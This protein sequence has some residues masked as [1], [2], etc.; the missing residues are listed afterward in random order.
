MLHLT[1]IPT[2]DEIDRELAA[3][4]VRGSLIDFTKTTFPGY[5]ANWHHERIAAAL[6]RWYRHET[7]RL[8]VSCPPRCGKS[9]LVSRRLPAWILGQNPD[10]QIIACSYGSSLASRMNR[11]AQRII[12]SPSYA[13]LY[14]GTRLGSENIRTLGQTGKWL[15]NS[16]LFEV[17]DHRG[18][19]RAAGVGGGITGLGADYAIIDDPIKDA[20]EANSPVV[21]EAV[22]EWYGSVL[23]TRLEH[24]ACVL[25]TMTRWHEDDLAGRLLRLARED[26]AADQWTVLR[27]PAI[28]EEPTADDPR[29]PGQ[30]LWPAKYD[31]DALAKIKASIG[32]Y[33]WQAIYQQRPSPPAGNLFTRGWWQ[34]YDAMPDVRWDV[35]VQSWDMAFKGEKQSDYVVG[36]VWGKTGG[37]FYLLDQ[38]RDRLSFS[39]TIDAVL[40]LSAKWPRTIAKFV[41]DKANGPAII[42]TLK[43]RVPGLIAVDPEGGKEARAAAISPLVEAENVF[44][45]RSTSWVNDF[46]EECANF[47]N[48][49]YD[50]QVDAMSQALLRLT[51]AQAPAG[52][53]VR[54]IAHDRPLRIMGAV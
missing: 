40:R 1:H 33:K 32:S 7:P 28:C 38:V 51:R 46:V 39:K 44:L 31:E 22:W 9:E 45:P 13:T 14:P 29:Q 36:Q 26:P 27:F 2:V 34:Y 37:R 47:P 10:A 21:R 50:D 18:V 52:A 43:R 16:D 48:G 30:A 11:D 35:L 19:Y 12:D 3:R 53:G 5:R 41:E 17:V 25:L 54:L 8:I 42:D 49:T 6:E 15:R 20:Q 24:G 23:H 4:S